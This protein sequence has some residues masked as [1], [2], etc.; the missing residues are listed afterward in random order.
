[1]EADLRGLDSHGLSRLP[2]YVRRVRKGLMEPRTEPEIVRETPVAAL[3]DA[4]H[5]LG[6]V[7]ADRA[8][9]IAAAKAK[10]VGMGCVGVRNSCIACR[11]P[12]KMGA[13][14]RIMWA[15]WRYYTLCGRDCSSAGLHLACGAER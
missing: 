9:R 11:G 15:P 6:I 1:M 7:V 10:E 2:V 12:G 5:G 13:R 8:M 4:R 14:R 3:M